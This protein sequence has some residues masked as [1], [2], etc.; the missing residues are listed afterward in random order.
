[1]RSTDDIQSLLLVSIR[2]AVLRM[3]ENDESSVVG[4]VSHLESQRWV[5]F[6][7]IALYLLSKFPGAAIPMV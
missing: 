6:R 1:M 7:R 3:G 5:L 2:D 4:V